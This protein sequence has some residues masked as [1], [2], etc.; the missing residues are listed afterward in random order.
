MKVSP[1]AMPAKLTP[2]TPSMPGGRI[3]PCQWM[4]VGSSSR[5]VTLST[6][7]CPSFRRISGPGLVPLMV[8][9][10]ADW[11]SIGSVSWRMASATS[12]P[13]SAPWA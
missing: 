13:S 2:G 9:G 10:R 8:I 3:R 12:G 7:S 5:L 1:G 4:E 6:A 11:P